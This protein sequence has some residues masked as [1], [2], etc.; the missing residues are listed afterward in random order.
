[1]ADILTSIQREDLKVEAGSQWKACINPTGLIRKRRAKG[2][3]I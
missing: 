3:S 2:K 1:M